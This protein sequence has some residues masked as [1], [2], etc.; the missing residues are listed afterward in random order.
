MSINGSIWDVPEQNWWDGR[1]QGQPAGQIPFAHTMEARAYRASMITFKSVIAGDHVAEFIPWVTSFS[2]NWSSDWSSEHV[3]GRSDPIYQWKST[4]R[5]IS[6]GFKAVA[7]SYREAYINMCNISKLTRMLYPHYADGREMLATAVGKAPLVRIRW[8]N[9]IMNSQDANFVPG[10][11][12][13]DY[14]DAHGLLGVIKSVSITPDLEE[15]MIE[16]PGP[17]SYFPK[18]WNISI[19]FGVLHENILGW[20]N[21]WEETDDPD[22]DSRTYGDSMYS[23]TG[24]YGWIPEVGSIDPTTSTGTAETGYPYGIKS[25]GCIN[26]NGHYPDSEGEG[27]EETG[28]SPDTDAGILEQQI[29]QEQFST[30]YSTN[31]GNSVV[32]FDMTDINRQ[33]SL[34]PSEGRVPV[35]RSVVRRF[36]GGTSGR[37]G[38]RGQGGY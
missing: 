19:D 34:S 37:S 13:D 38:T 15:G 4:G 20:T 23:R 35:G 21:V 7:G 3:F 27:V 25:T 18:L 24:G 30:F 2:D 28:E 31:D 8:A 17:D 36:T 1:A 12:S 14:M 16:G 6:L 10:Q 32:D 9:L 22:S 26:N 33:R 29:R 11:G 5:S